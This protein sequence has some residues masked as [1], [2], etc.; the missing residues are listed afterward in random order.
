MIKED[1]GVYFPLGSLFSG[2]SGLRNE[3]KEGRNGGLDWHVR[4]A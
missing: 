3:E 1:E 4:H 2:P